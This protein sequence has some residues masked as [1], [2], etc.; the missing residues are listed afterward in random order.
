[1]CIVLTQTFVLCAH[2]V[3][4]TAVGG[5]DGHIYA[6]IRV[7][8]VCACALGRATLSHMATGRIG[9]TLA[10]KTSVLRR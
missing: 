9:I 4:Y 1:M 2:N 10:A 3:S 8:A 6:D 7:P 5:A